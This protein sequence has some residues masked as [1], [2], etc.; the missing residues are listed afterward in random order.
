MDIISPLLTLDID[1]DPSIELDPPSHPLKALHCASGHGEYDG[2]HNFGGKC[3]K[4]EVVFR[5][6]EKR[7]IELIMEKV[8]GFI[9]CAVAWFTN[10]NILDALAEAV[11]RGVYVAVVVQKEDF[12]RPDRKEK[13]ESFKA[14][15]RRKY[16]ALDMVDTYEFVQRYLCVLAQDAISD[17]DGYLY[18]Y[19]S[20][21]GLISAVRCVGNH[22]VDKS[23]SFPRMHH[24]F[25]VFGDKFTVPCEDTIMDGGE[26]EEH[27]TLVPR[28]VWTGSFNASVTACR[29][30]ENAVIIE[31]GA[32]AKKYAQE[33]S[34][35]FMISE[36]LD[37]TSDWIAPTFE[38]MT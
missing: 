30:F 3:G 28:M 29:S 34:L 15:L 13:Y 31:G 26:F 5:N 1:Y 17:C 32:E 25:F 38:Y 22:N 18:D 4:A 6:H 27:E 35:M 7:L 23:S 19:S 14:T 24:K 12:L 2:T 21:S 20:I 33:F 10:Y 37:W 16:D 9:F 8:D 11:G 36:P